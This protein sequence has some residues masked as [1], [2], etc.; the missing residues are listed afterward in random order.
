MVAI[1]LLYASDLRVGYDFLVEG[2]SETSLLIRCNVKVSNW[3][4]IRV[5]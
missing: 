5:Y 2:D 1:V 3:L 4:C